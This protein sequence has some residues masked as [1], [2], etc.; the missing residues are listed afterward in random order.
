MVL[1]PHAAD[2]ERACAAPAEPQP[3]A[4]PQDSE[5]D[6]C[7]QAGADALR[8][9]RTFRARVTEGVASAVE[10]VLADVAVDVLARELQLAPAS[11]DVIVERALQRYFS[12]APMRVRVHPA[13]AD[14]LTC[15]VPVVA[16]ERLRE[17]D[18]VIEL[19]CGC[20]DAG[21]GARL[22]GVL[23]ALRS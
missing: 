12:E 3:A 2:G 23:A 22:A 1:E 5:F 14:A 11:I 16:D 4:T 7:F 10:T 18:A 15:S 9:V 8:D 17:G 21:L 6:E 19:R 20:V 13:Q